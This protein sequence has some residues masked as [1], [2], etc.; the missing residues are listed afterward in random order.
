MLCNIYITLYNTY[1]PERQVIAAN[2][3]CFVRIVRLHVPTLY[4]SWKDLLHAPAVG[5]QDA[6]PKLCSY[7]RPS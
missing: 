3:T 4:N 1:I 2:V 6:I 7:L 5:V